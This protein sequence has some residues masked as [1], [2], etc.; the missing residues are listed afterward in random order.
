MDCYFKN[1]KYTASTRKSTATRWF[2]CK[3]SPLKNIETIIPNTRQDIT[4][5][6]TFSCT[7]EKGP[8]FISL[9][10]RL[11]GIK[12]EYSRSAIP[13]L[14]SIMKIIGVLVEM[15]FI[16]CNFRLPYQARVIKLFDMMSSARVR[17]IFVILYNN[18]TV[19]FLFL[20]VVI[21]VVYCSLLPKGCSVPRG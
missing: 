8:P 1:T 15:I 5:C 20:A 6:I 9:P 17:I 12:N 3:D 7:S 10:M 19:S 2:H 11:A 13:Q 21:R 14:M 16:S 4:S 18:F